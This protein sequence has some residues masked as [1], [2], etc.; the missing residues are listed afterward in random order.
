SFDSNIRK[1]PPRRDANV[2]IG[3]LEHV[4]FISIQTFVMSTASI[5]GT[6]GLP[7]PSGERGG[8]RGNQP[9][10]PKPPHPTLSPAGRGSRSCSRHARGSIRPKLALAGRRN[11]RPPS[12]RPSFYQAGL[13][14]LYLQA[15][16]LGVDAA[17]GETAG[18]KPESRLVRAHEH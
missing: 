1:S 12:G 8:G 13:G 11:Q 2:R 4:P 7:L 14:G 16:I 9:P 15:E 17:L 10:D 5:C 6:A 3:P 18:D